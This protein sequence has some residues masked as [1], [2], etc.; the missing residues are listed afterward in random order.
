MSRWSFASGGSYN[1][2]TDFLDPK[3]QFSGTWWSIWLSRLFSLLNENNL[4][5]PDNH[6]QQLLVTQIE[7]WYT[8]QFHELIKALQSIPYYDIIIYPLTDKL[9]K[10]FQYA[11][12]K[13]IEQVVI[14][15]PEEQ[16]QWHFIIKNLRSWE[17]TIYQL[18]YSY[19]VIPYIQK[20][21]QILVCLV[22]NNDTNATR[23]FPKGH[24]DPG[25]SIIQTIHRECKEEI[26]WEII[27]D[28]GKE[29]FYNTYFIHKEHRQKYKINR[30]VLGRLASQHTTKQDEE[31]RNI[32]RLTPQQILQTDYLWH[33]HNIIKQSWLINKHF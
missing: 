3:Q 6:Q 22:Q 33:L 14:Y 4:Y 25:E 5:T 19:G 13:G 9:G 17:Q 18:D 11:E 26:W 27:D 24:Q 28:L 12:K 8:Q 15:G 21:N 23:S 32:K 2:F 31:I 20:D 30:F 29:F 1:N 10:Q 7:W 16:S